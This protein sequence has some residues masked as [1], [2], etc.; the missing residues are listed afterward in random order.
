MEQ[1]AGFFRQLRA[2]AFDHPL[3]G[4]KAL[5]Q[6]AAGRRPGEGRVVRVGVGLGHG[7]LDRQIPRVKYPVNLL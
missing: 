6:R 1:F 2:A 7:Q 5:G 4:R 3:F